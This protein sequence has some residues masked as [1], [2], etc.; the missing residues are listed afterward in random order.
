MER[1]DG[2]AVV[3]LGISGNVGDGLAQ[4]AKEAGAT[5]FGT[6]RSQQRSASAEVFVGDASDPEGARVLAEAIRQR[7][8]AVDHVIASMGPWW[9][10]KGSFEEQ[11]TEAWAQVRRMLLDSHVHAAAAFLPLVKTSGS[12]TIITG[13]GAV[14]PM[15]TA[16]LLTIALGG[17][18][19]LSR[20]L[21]FEHRASGCR[22]NEVRIS[23]RI[24]KVAR[25]SV[26]PSIDMG[27]AL[28]RLL[29]SPV[30]SAVVPF[31]TSQS[32]DP[33]IHLNDEPEGLR[34]SGPG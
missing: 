29:S 21:R 24:E 33:T 7:V 18:L 27:R 25:P 23:S 26:I 4:A 8:G 13:Q 17:T 12:Y 14:N 28:L 3:V 16:H 15:P 30:R 34:P 10:A 20:V 9:T 31:R 19:A 22:V 6:S 5:V 32:F 2:Q 1:L 11:P